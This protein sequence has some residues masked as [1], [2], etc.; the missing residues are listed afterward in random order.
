MKSVVNATCVCVLI[1]RA[2]DE[3]DFV[4][5]LDG[6]IADQRFQLAD[7]GFNDRQRLG[8]VL[9]RGRQM[10]RNRRELLGNQLACTAICLPAR[11]SPKRVR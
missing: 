6:R 3:R 11:S 5:S 10:T 7:L 1:D 2:A 4:A 8:K 9:R